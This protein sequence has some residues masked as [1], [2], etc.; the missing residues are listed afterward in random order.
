MSDIGSDGLTR[1]EV[2]KLMDTYQQQWK[3]RFDR[4]AQALDRNTAAMTDGFTSI[5]EAMDAH[6]ADDRLVADRVLRIETERG[7]EKQIAGRR[8]AIAGTVTASL[9]MALFEA[10]KKAFGH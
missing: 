2:W 7:I 1:A 10:M 3:E 5:R 9:V 6:A 8:G 4:H